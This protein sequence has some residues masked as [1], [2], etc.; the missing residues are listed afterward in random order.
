M[1]FERA[2]DCIEWSERVTQAA[3]AK[4]CSRRNDWSCEHGEHDGESYVRARWGSQDVFRATRDGR[5]HEMTDDEKELIAASL[6]WT[7]S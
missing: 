5:L 2:E 1:Q 6:G 7:L 3:S 4:L